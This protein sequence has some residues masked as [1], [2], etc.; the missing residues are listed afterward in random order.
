MRRQLEYQKTY[1]SQFVTQKKEHNIRMKFNLG[2][3]VANHFEQEVL[4]S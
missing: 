2:I 1:N 3:E 4:N